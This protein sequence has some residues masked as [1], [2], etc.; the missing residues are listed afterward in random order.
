MEV[1]MMKTTVQPIQGMDYLSD[2]VAAGARFVRLKPNEKVPDAG[3][4][5]NDPRNV[6]R[7]HAQAL[8]GIKDG[9]NI[10]ILTGAGGIIDIDIDVRV[11]E[12]PDT[13]RRA[14]ADWVCKYLSL[15]FGASASWGRRMGLGDAPTPSHILYRLVDARRGKTQKLNY[16]ELRYKSSGG[17]YMQS[18]I[19]PSIHP[20]GSALVWLTPP[21]NLKDVEYEDL[22]RA[23]RIADAVLVLAESYT[24]GKRHNIVGALSGWLLRN[25]WTVDEVAELVKALC[26]YT[27]DSEFS[28]RLQFLYDTASKLSSGEPVVGLPTIVGMVGDNIARQLSKS[29]AVAADTPSRNGHAPRIDGKDEKEAQTRARLDML[30]QRA[31]EAVDAIYITQKDKTYVSVNRRGGRY[32]LDV[33]SPN[34]LVWAKQNL[35]YFG[36]P[37]IS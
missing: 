17:A 15:R 33:Q 32:L 1:K 37:P 26:D 18:M 35:R 20:D 4:G 19:P 22:E 11:M 3:E 28:D 16:L 36:E 27:G 9:Y 5:W 25:G 21:N 14:A 29:L 23:V 2:L 24:V 31:L 13:V 30:I 12:A 7:V 34:F 8:Q 6:E 10:G